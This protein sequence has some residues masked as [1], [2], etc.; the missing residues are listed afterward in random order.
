MINSA[1]FGEYWLASVGVLCFSRR[2]ERGE[3]TNVLMNKT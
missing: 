3:G 2:I 1:C